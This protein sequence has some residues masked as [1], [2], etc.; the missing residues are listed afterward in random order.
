MVFVEKID[1][2][3]KYFIGEERVKPDRRVFIFRPGD[4][5]GLFTDLIRVF[6]TDN[7]YVSTIV[8]VDL[9]GEG[10]I[11]LD[12]YVVF[13]PGEEVIVFRT[14]IPRDKPEIDTLLDLIPGVFNAESEVYDLMGIVFRGNNTLKRGFFVPSDLVE[15][16]IYPL[17]KDS[18]V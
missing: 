15:K 18:G 13:L 9:V 11:R 2:F 10:R 14:F 8:A 17:R 7:F 1:L 4:L 5:R 16:N 3:R 6:G 12:Y